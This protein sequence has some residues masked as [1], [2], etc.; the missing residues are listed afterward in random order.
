LG[1]RQQRRKKQPTWLEV[2]IP[3]RG[4]TAAVD[5]RLAAVP[6]D[7]VRASTAA[8]CKNRVQRMQ[9]SRQRRMT[10]PMRDL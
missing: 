4:I 3:A 9:P 8:G 2:P 7:T 5:E 6:G 10:Q 1:F